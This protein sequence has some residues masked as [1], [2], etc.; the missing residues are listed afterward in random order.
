MGKTFVSRADLLRCMLVEKYLDFDRVADALGFVREGLFHEVVP[1]KQ[2][3]E[4]TVSKM[5]TQPAVATKLPPVEQEKMHFYRMTRRERLQ[6]QPESLTG[7]PDWYE[8]SNET[9]LDEERESLVPEHRLLKFKPL[10]PWS[11]LW[12]FLHKTLSNIQRGSKVDVDQLV[13][14]LAQ[15][16]LI[17]R[18]PVKSN[19]TWAGSARLLI[20]INTGTFPLRH[21]FIFLYEKLISLRGEYGLQV[22]YLDDQPGENVYYW[23]NKNEIVERWSTP[24]S[25]MPFLIISDL[26]ALSRSKRTLYNWLVFGRK[27]AVKGCRPVALMPVPLRMIDSR[28]LTYFD[29]V[30]W[31]RG[32]R[33]KALKSVSP[34]KVQADGYQSKVKQLLCRLAPAVR[35]NNVLLREARYL[36]SQDRFDVGHE[37]AV[38][39]HPSI[40]NHGDEFVWQPNDHEMFMQEFR[41]FSHRLQQTM[42]DL[43]ARYHSRLPEVVYFEAMLNCIQLAPKEVSLVINDAVERY[44]AALVRTCEEY[45]RYQGLNG[46]EG[47]FLRRQKAEVLRRKNKIIA[48]IEG[49]R[50]KR[51]AQVGQ[52]IICPAGVDKE[53]MMPFLVET[54]KSE[55]FELRQQGREL[56]LSP[57]GILQ[58]AEGFSSSGS[59]LTEIESRVDY[60]LRHTSTKQNLRGSHI[61]KFD[62]ERKVTIALAGTRSYEL[63]TDLEKITIEPL[64][65]PDWAMT[66]GND[67]HGLYAKSK[68]NDSNVYTWYWNPFIAERLGSNDRSAC[69]VNKGFWYSELIDDGHS[70]KIPDWVKDANCDQYGLYAD[71]E[72]LGITQRF[73]WIEPTSFLMGSP[74]DEVDRYDDETQHSVILTQGYWMADT[75]CAQ[76][77]WEA[78]MH[79][80]PS[81]FKG[82]SRPVENVNWDDIQDF[83]E[84]L[85]KHYPELK[86]RL[87]TE[88][89][90]ENACRAVGEAKDPFNFEGDLSLA[91]VNY[92]GTWDD[93]DNWGDGALKQTVDVK[94]EK[95]QPNMW[96]LHQMHG[97]VW[98]WCQDWYA[99]YPTESAV[100]PQGAESGDSRVLRGGSWL[101]DGW[102]C[103]SAYRADDD[104]SDRDGDIGFRLARGHELSPVR[105][106]KAGQQPAGSR[107]RS[108]ARG[109]Q[110]GDGLRAPDSMQKP[111]KSTGKKQKNLLD[112]AKGLFKK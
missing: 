100:D 103:R 46:W 102:D 7:Y 92:R 38:W 107:E 96:G 10:V 84:K 98:E 63:E 110:T 49:I 50:W 27:L 5:L 59:L 81:Q 56:I 90:W 95:Y 68:D 88:A 76:A 48:A 12:P 87:P 86:L 14:K 72:I 80:N 20:D 8:A 71:V 51:T 61:L 31:D 19:S 112:R 93:Y 70:Y 54:K 74:D 15:G 55:T 43:I 44:M 17:R 73:R 91:K 94:I 18:L 24:D 11:R 34:D 99:N 69:V 85:N 40:Q 47:R 62:S 83:I 26:G 37:A 111:S 32:N 89:E 1:K 39:Q 42:I 4:T 53:L 101:S 45:P 30:S 9:L 52:E 33:L 23:D 57:K 105:T 79:D 58:S 41:K 75:T 64:V 106:V 77:L 66:I 108:G 97:N 104:P 13:R 3:S 109:G 78:V 65:R 28:L 36:Y 67:A 35:I 82:E 6:A 60:L 2:R 22:Q 21:D 16:E 29:C 25:D